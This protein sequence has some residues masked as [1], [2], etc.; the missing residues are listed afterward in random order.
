[1]LVLTAWSGPF[2]W[3][4]STPERDDGDGTDG[5][6]RTGD[7]DLLL[8]SEGEGVRLDRV[9]NWTLLDSAIVEAKN[10]RAP[11]QFGLNYVTKLSLLK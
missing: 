6:D 11:P 3:P 9:V 1:M 4:R 10:H 5:T 7:E 2:S 8:W